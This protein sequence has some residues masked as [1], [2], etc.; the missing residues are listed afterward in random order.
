MQ[1]CGSR[2]LFFV[3]TDLKIYKMARISNVISFEGRNERTIVVIYDIISLVLPLYFNHFLLPF[4]HFF[5]GAIILRP[6]D[7]LMNFS[8]SHPIFQTLLIFHLRFIIT[9]ILNLIERN[10]PQSTIYSFKV[11]RALRS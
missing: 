8:L 6:D 9:I 11:I 5:H 2:V 3:N 10:Q 1:H 4:A 7:F